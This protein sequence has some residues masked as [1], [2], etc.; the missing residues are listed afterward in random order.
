MA[1]LRSYLQRA[2]AALKEAQETGGHKGGENNYN[3]S[4]EAGDDVDEHDAGLF[5]GNVLEEIK[6]SEFRL[7]CDKHCS[8]SME[9]IIK[10][11][12]PTQLAKLLHRL[13]ENWKELLCHKFGSHVCQ[14]A[15]DRLSSIFTKPELDLA[16]LLPDEEA[17]PALSTQFFELC[18]QIAADVNTLM[19][20]TYA[21]HVLRVVICVLA[22]LPLEKLASTLRSRS[23][24]SFHSAMVG[25]EQFANKKLTAAFIIAARP[26]LIA[27][28]EQL[29]AL[30]DVIFFYL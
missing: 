5:V 13:K 29:L 9:T 8:A 12:P 6:E 23:S 22:G 20:D 27:L 7:C 10:L 19:Q 21:S 11:S 4:G 24:Q 28:A 26:S 14:T 15:V 16:T 17:P 2:A 1:D 30:P 18:E 25:E 3:G